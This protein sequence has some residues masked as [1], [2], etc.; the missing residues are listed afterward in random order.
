MMSRLS[1]CTPATRAARPPPGARAACRTAALRCLLLGGACAQEAAIR[2][3]HQA[4]V[5]AVH[6][7][8]HL[9][10]P[11][12]PA[13][14]ARLGDESLARVRRA[15]GSE[16]ASPPSRPTSRSSTAP[17]PSPRRAGWR[18]CRRGSCPPTRRSRGDRVHSVAR[19][20]LAQLDLAG[21]CRSGSCCRRRS[22]CG[23]RTRSADRPAPRIS[24]LVP[25]LPR[26]ASLPADALTTG[27]PPPRR[28]DQPPK[29]SSSRL[30]RRQCIG[31]GKGE[32][33]A[34]GIA[35]AKEVHRLAAVADPVGLE[36]LAPLVKG[37]A[38]LA[39]NLSNVGDVA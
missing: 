3:R 11:A 34:D 25:T 6:L 33:V 23:P 1:L 19:G 27:S 30:R 5:L 14:D 20:P 29:R 2:L 37:A 36:Q 8:V 21:A 39:R 28:R 31:D 9:V 32:G 15:I 13:H 7:A 17:R 4:A 22:S 12:A 35:V 16:G 10:D 24:R 18:G 38:R 26:P